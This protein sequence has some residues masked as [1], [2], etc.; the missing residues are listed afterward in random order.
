MILFGGKTIKKSELSQLARWA[1]ESL[2]D[3]RKKLVDVAG[4]QMNGNLKT[5]GR[6][7]DLSRPLPKAVLSAPAKLYRAHKRLARAVRRGK[8]PWA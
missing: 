1:P 3:A 6:T 8:K 7:M 2:V 5:A 4:S